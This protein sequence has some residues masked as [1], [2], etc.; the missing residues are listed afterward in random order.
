MAQQALARDAPSTVWVAV[1][2]LSTA[3]ANAKA[4]A[5]LGRLRRDRIREDS[6]F[7]RRSS[8]ALRFLI[9]ESTLVEDEAREKRD[10]VLL[11]MSESPYRCALKYILWYEH[12]LRAFP[13]AKFIA[14]G[15][16]DVYV[17]LE[18]L[19]LNLRLLHAQLSAPQLATMARGAHDDA[20]VLWGQVQRPLFL[21]S[22][23]HG[24]TH[25]STHMLS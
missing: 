9:A 7:F 22:D 25:H 5:S 13:A 19:E 11:N 15:D 24:R 21:H 4:N 3:G 14:N 18:R 23:T 17:H 10:I 8:T 20:H 1:G 16:D 12:A 2:L 6:L